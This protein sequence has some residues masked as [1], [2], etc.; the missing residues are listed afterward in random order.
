MME[1]KGGQKLENVYHVCTDGMSRD[2]LFKDDKDFVKGMNAVAVC[3]QSSG[4][5]IL[6]F[7]LMSNHVHFILKGPYEECVRF[8]RLY[9]QRVNLLLG[10]K[11]S[12]ISVRQVD[13][14]DY[15]KNA[16]AYVLRNPVAARL[17]VMPGEYRW[18]SGSCYFADASIHGRRLRKVSSVGI[19][20]RRKLFNTREVLPDSFLITD[21]G[22]ILPQCYVDFKAVES[23]YRT[24]AAMLYYLARNVDMEAE[25]AT[26]ILRK[27]RYSDQE[28]YNSAT[29]L[30]SSMFRKNGL[31]HLTIEEKLSLAKALRQRYGISARQLSR[32]L[33]IDLRL[34]QHLF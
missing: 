6:C 9:K 17:S 8:I 30:G 22:L 5:V 14:P 32:L 27:A 28:L 24:P 2:I 18:G 3:K 12:D 10:G 26:G 7:C 31:S 21:D 16:I 19:A 15:L 33:G 4:I 29:V 25:L 11:N 23:L 34:L 20:E 13:T 1:M